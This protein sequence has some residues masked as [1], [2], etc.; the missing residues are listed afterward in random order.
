M[1]LEVL[2]AMKMSVVVVWLV[3]LCGFV[4]G[5]MFLRNVGT[6]HL[7]VIFQVLTAASMKMAVFCDVVLCSL[8][9]IDRHFIGAYC[10]HRRPDDGCS[11]HL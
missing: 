9:K 1:K 4:S 11:K 5:S 6:A 2:T 8:V 3:M 10:L 7:Q